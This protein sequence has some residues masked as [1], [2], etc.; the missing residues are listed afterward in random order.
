MGTAEIHTGSAYRS[1]REL[2]FKRLK[3]DKWL[4]I[5]LTPGLLYFLLFKYVPMWGFCSRSR[6]S[7]LSS[8]S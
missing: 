7:S 4:Y 1:K 2:I 5:L 8:A 3:R 6:I